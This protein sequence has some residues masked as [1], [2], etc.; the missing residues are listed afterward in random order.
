MYTNKLFTEITVGSALAKYDGEHIDEDILLIEDVSKLPLP[1]EPRRMNSILVG[2]CLKGTAQYN[3]DTVVHTC[4]ANCVILVSTAQVID[5]YKLSDDFQGVGFLLSPH[6]FSEIAKEVHELAQLF[7]FARNHPVSQ[8]LP[9]EANAQ[10]EY[11]HILQRKM[12]EKGH[13][14]RKDVVRMILETMNYE[15]GN[16]IFRIMNKEDNKKISR[17]EQIF[18]DFIQLVERN[19]RTERKVS[20]YSLQLC[21]TPKYLSETVRQVSQLTPNEW[22]DRYVVMEIRVLLKT[23]RMSIKQIAQELNFP[24]QSFLGRFFMEHTGMSPSAYRKS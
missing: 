14:F 10:L 15:L 9:E 4:T 22:I 11:F 2:L 12:Q 23:S 13:H 17:A 6:F 3:V 16:V 21:I 5:A 19:F 24:N 8:L 1:D 20:W 18:S 7:L